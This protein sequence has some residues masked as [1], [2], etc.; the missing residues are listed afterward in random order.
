MRLKKGKHHLVPREHNAM[1]A[2]QKD[3]ETPAP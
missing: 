1:W 2:V 3:A